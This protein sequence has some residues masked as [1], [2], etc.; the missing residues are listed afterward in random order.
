MLYEPALEADRS[1]SPVE[2]FKDRPQ[3]LELK[4][5]EELP[6]IVGRGFASALL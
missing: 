5:P 2:V 1:I 4:D 6:K 3:Q